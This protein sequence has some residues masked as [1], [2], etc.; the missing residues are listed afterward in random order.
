M[1]NPKDDGS[2][3]LLVAPEQLKGFFEVVGA[4]AGRVPPYQRRKSLVLIAGEIPWVF[5]EQ[6]AAALGY[7]LFFARSG[8]AFRCAGLPRPP[9]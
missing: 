1:N 5:Q 8:D 7:R 2:L 3:G 6:P 4:D 9:R